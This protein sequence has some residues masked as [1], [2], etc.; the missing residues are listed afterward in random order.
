MRMIILTAVL[1]VAG[2][3]YAKQENY[4][5]R[6]GIVHQCKQIGTPVGEDG[7]W[8]ACRQGIVDGY[9]DL[10][11]D[12]CDRKGRGN[13]REFWRCPTELSTAYQP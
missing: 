7:S 13:E 6:A 8:V 3:A 2:L 9:P 4:F 5:A 11:L 1:I 12:S 10:A